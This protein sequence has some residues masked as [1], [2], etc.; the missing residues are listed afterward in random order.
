MERLYSLNPE[1]SVVPRTAHAA[2]TEFYK[3]TTKWSSS[4]WDNTPELL[5]RLSSSLPASELDL[6]EKWVMN[7]SGIKQPHP[8]VVK[9]PLPSCEDEKVELLVS[10]DR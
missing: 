7:P 2:V 4:Q 8:E 5:I 9:C 10:S 3:M 6:F 1:R